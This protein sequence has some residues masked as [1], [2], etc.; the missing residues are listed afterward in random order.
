MKLIVTSAHMPNEDGRE[1]LMLLATLMWHSVF[2]L[3][4]VAP[5]VL[6][7]LRHIV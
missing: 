5:H 6:V 4:A 7:V 1:P 3:W 2:L